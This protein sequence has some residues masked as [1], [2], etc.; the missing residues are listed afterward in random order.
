LC[1][2]EYIHEKNHFEPLPLVTD[3][4]AHIE[5]KYEKRKTIIR[6]EIK[7]QLG[8]MSLSLKASQIDIFGDEAVRKEDN[9]EE[10]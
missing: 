1:K 5:A 3:D 2:Y 7:N 4:Y 9:N 6:T 10:Q 8:V